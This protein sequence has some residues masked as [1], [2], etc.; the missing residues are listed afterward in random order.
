MYGYMEI[1]PVASIV[2]GFSGVAGSRVGGFGRSGVEEFGRQGPK[3]RTRSPQTQ[4]L[5]PKP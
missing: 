2:C 1:N 5:N 4:T 3:P